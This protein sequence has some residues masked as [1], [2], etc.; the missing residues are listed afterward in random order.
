MLGLPA[1]IR[2]DRCQDIRRVGNVSTNKRDVDVLGFL[3]HL[4]LQGPHVAATLIR[5]VEGFSSVLFQAV[6][7]QLARHAI[8]AV[9]WIP[10][11][12]VE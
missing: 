2:L 7:D 9:G 5:C 12:N 10:T 11:L 6:F 4:C 8:V 1:F 3:S